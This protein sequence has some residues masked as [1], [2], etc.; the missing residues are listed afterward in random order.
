[1]LFR[2][3]TPILSAVDQFAKGAMA[4]MH[5][6]ALLRAEVKTLREANSSLAKRR[7]AKKTR[8]RQGG[9]LKIGE[10]QGLL[11]QKDVDTQLGEET[12]IRSGRA[13]RS[14]PRGRRCGICGTAGHNARTCEIDV[15]TSGESDSD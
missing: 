10:A 4:I 8:L 5:E 15:E 2:S 1:M 9:T 12:R 11:D 7:R 3:P 6:N 13:T 14:E